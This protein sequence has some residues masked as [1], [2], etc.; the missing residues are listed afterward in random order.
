[1]NEK[2]PFINNKTLLIVS[3]V[4]GSGKTS[5]A[6]YL[7]HLHPDSVVCTADD[8]HMQDGEY[9]FDINNLGAAHEW[10]KQKAFDAMV[11]NVGLIIVGNTNTQ[12]KEWKPYKDN[13]EKHGYAVSGIVMQNLGGFENVHN[14]PEEVLNKQEMRLR[15]NIKLK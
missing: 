14:V 15:E 7:A 4:S 12:P 11:K 1:M 2:N 9:K 13:A 10:C 5:F 6:D 3:G 8:Y